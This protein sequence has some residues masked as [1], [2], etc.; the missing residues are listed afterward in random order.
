MRSGILLAVVLGGTSGV[1][2]DTI[3]VPG[4]YPTIQAGMDAAQAGD[5][6]LVAD[7]IYTGRGNKNLIYTGVPLTLRSE[8][9]AESCIIDCEGIGLG[10]WLALNEP[11]DFIID[12]FTIRNGNSGWAGAFFFHHSCQAIIRNC[13][14]TQCTSTFGGALYCEDTSS[15]TLINCVITANTAIRGGGLFIQHSSSPT[16][17]NCT[18]TNNIADTNGGGVYVI[19]GGTNPRFINCTITDN[20]AKRSGGGFY[21]ANGDA[22][23]VNS[24]V[25]RNTGGQITDNSENL[26][27]RYSN[28]EGGWPGQ[29]NI[30]AD[31]LF[32][33]P[34]NGDYHLSPGSPSIDAADNTAVPKGID[35]DLDGRNR[36]VDTRCTDDTGK[37]KPPIVD[38][39]AYEFQVFQVTCPW[40]VDCNGSVGAADLLELLVS[41]GPCK[42]CPADF[43]HNGNVGASELLALLANWGP[44]P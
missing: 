25:R 35:T 11:P 1:V 9:G 12:G 43:N 22:V 2:A 31:P 21:V 33:D 44:C 23:I 10:F 8:N 34:D 4:D 17:I 5:T 18:I 14:I 28:V 27:V 3:H 7:G 24:I 36:F 26:T 30:D 40:D 37:G 19:S 20:L 39:G 42:G 6:V 13:V 15:P 29:G 32:V 16:L 38:M 41:W